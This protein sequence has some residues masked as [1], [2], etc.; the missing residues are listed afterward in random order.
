ME[1]S[2]IHCAAI[3]ASLP[4]RHRLK[5]K[6]I[7][8]I[9]ATLARR[10]SNLLMCH[11][12]DLPCVLV[13]SDLRSFC[14]PCHAFWNR[15]I[16]VISGGHLP[17]VSGCVILAPLAS[18]P[19]DLLLLMCLSGDYLPFL[20]LGLRRLSCFGLVLH[21]V[22]PP[23]ACLHRM[24]PSLYGRP[25]F[26]PTGGWTCFAKYCRSSTDFIVIGVNSTRYQRL[27]M[28]FIVIG[29]ISAIY[30]RL[31]TDFIVIGISF[32]EFDGST[33]ISKELKYYYGENWYFK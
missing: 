15:L 12:G 11:F 29:I 7:C 33:R 23:S 13:S 28:D 4:S 25:F 6:R 20:V 14:Q 8:D 22:C 1:M 31:N 9:L 5:R 16:C 24:F 17:D 3:R 32:Y 19:W 30:Q 2:V 26:P 10:F 18:L 21:L 27:Y